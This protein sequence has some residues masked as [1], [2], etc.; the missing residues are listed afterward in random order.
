MKSYLNVYPGSGQIVNTDSGGWSDPPANSVSSIWIPNARTRQLSAGPI[1]HGDKTSPNPHGFSVH[2]STCLSGR[3]VTRTYGNKFPQP[4]GG[5]GVINTTVELGCFQEFPDPHPGNVVSD[6]SYNNALSKFNEELRGNLDLSVALAE[7]PK[8]FKMLK[9]TIGLAKYV[10]GFHPRHW[11][12]HYLE[13]KFGWYPLAMDVYNA[14]KELSR[15]S[16]QIQKVKGRAKVANSRTSV[17][18][19]NG[20]RKRSVFYSSRRTEIG[21]VYTASNSTVD[22]IGRWA[23]LSPASVAWELLPGSWI[24]DYMINIGG[25]LRSLESSLVLSGG[26]QN[27]YLSQGALDRVDTYVSG[28]GV[29]AGSRLYSGTKY[30]YTENKTFTRSVLLGVPSPEV[31]RFNSNLGATQQ[32][33]VAA[34]LGS[35]LNTGGSNVAKERRVSNARLDEMLRNLRNGPRVWSSNPEHRN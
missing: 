29:R 12:G 21:A 19:S 35:F 7:A 33:T 5:F 9:S 10:L 8:T 14:S 1:V 17:T 20:L 22:A 23:S 3:M 6:T 27:G 16:L 2:D 4:G 25:A 18:V 24:V 13:Y 30:G 26:S 34:L 15:Q 28:T 11:A 31:P 32:L